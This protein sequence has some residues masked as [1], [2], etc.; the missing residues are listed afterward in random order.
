MAI[1]A[2]KTNASRVQP[3]DRI[4]VKHY[5]R[6]NEADQA[7]LEY[8]GKDHALAISTTKTGA[9]VT[10]ARVLHTEA[11]QVTGGRRERRVYNIYTT[12]GVLEHNAPAQTMILAPEDTAGVK[13]AHVEALEINAVMDAYPLAEELTEEEAAQEV[14]DLEAE[15]VQD[16]EEYQ[17]S[18][19]RH[20]LGHIGCTAGHAEVQ[21]VRDHLDSARLDL[22]IG[23]GMGTP[24]G[25]VMDEALSRAG[26]THL[27]E[28]QAAVRELDEAQR[29]H[30]DSGA[31]VVVTD[32]DQ[33]MRV[34]DAIRG[35]R[36]DLGHAALEV[37]GTS[38]VLDPPRVRCEP[39]DVVRIHRGTQLWEV[40]QVAREAALD[41]ATGA[42]EDM[43]QARLVPADPASQRD[44]QWVS[45]DLLHVVPPVARVSTAP[46][47]HDAGGR[48]SLEL[49]AVAGTGWA[50]DRG[51][52][53]QVATA[54]IPG[55][56]VPA[57]YL[58]SVEHQ[59][60]VPV[61][62]LGC[63]RIGDAIVVD[64]RCFRVVWDELEGQEP[65]LEPARW[66]D[67]LARL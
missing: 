13:R 11:A 46:I 10:V 4:L 19:A 6:D 26:F 53:R 38:A 62:P 51:V 22:G 31:P 17:V 21:A 30:L 42:L 64:G 8:L 49:V 44:P 32:Q 18:P 7:T 66:R 23:L 41:T 45:V 14:R 15:M 9:G 34:V 5:T 37:S 43:S 60:G 12:E 1:A 65:H 58:L 57:V 50:E 54:P 35:F 63:L 40:V 25:P 2:G 48:I 47:P 20:P 55:R 3:G 33:A 24:S 56:C 28:Y 16:A 59:D 27:T 29:A 36:G 39:G 67:R 61:Q 52:L